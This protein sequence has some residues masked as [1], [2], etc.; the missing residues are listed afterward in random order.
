MFTKE[1]RDAMRQELLESFK[2][3]TPPP[4]PTAEAKMQALRVAERPDEAIMQDAAKAAKA[5]LKM[6]E[7]WRNRRQEQEAKE[8]AEWNDPRARYQ[9][10]L[11]N[12]WQ[13][14]RDLEATL[15][16][17]YVQVGGFREPRRSTCHRGKG[18]PD[19]GL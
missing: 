13:L 11:D 18:D 3:K 10:Q 4:K 8:M 2:P 5:Q 1:E 12:W 9:R 7:R 14:Q 6:A 15:D 19:W 17:G 16:D